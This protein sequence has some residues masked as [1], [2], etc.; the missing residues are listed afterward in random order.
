[1]SEQSFTWVPFYEEL[2]KKLLEYKTNRSE[3]IEII[4]EVYNE[5]KMDITKVFRL[6]DQPD[7][8]PFTLFTEF[9]RSIKDETR[10]KICKAYKEIFGLNTECP[11]DFDGIPVRTNLRRRFYTLPG[12][13]KYNPECFDILWGLFET[14]LTDD[15]NR[16]NSRFNELFNESLKLNCVALASLSMALFWIQPK[17]YVNLDAKNSFYL[18]DSLKFQL[19]Q[20][21][22][23]IEYL[24]LCKQV[25]DKAKS[26]L[27]EL[28]F[29]AHQQFE[30]RLLP[31]NT[32]LS[33]L[34]N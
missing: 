30:N 4:R 25:I 34:L 31:P 19:K 26:S 2:A 16:D 24:N 33:A 22:S 27:P 3:L 15:N 17:R 28:S 8:D 12:D 6:K 14:A 13:K 29:S 9:N 11:S 7:I 20:E 23:G 21:Y 1:M 10:I 32:M 5:C 18:Y